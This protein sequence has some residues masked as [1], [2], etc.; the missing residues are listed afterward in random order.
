MAVVV[1]QQTNKSQKRM[2]KKHTHTHTHTHS[3]SII[4]YKRVDDKSKRVMFQI[5]FPVSSSPFF[6]HVHRS[7]GGEEQGIFLLPLGV[8]Y[9]L[10]LLLLLLL[11]YAVSS[12]SNSDCKLE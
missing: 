11:F 12:A 4:T 9:L 8:H 2:V 3:N 7:G 5:V 10:L 6:S 1:H